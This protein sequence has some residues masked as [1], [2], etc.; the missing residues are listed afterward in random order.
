MKLF[1]S[2]L[3]LLSLL[4]CVGRPEPAPEPAAPTYL[5]QYAE[6]S[7]LYDEFKGF[8]A[9]ELFQRHGFTANSPYADWLQRVR[10]LEE[11]SG[12]AARAR[13]LAGL[14]VAWRQNGEMSEVTAG[15]VSRFEQALLT[16]PEEQDPAANATAPGAVGVAVSI[17]FSGD[18]QGVLTPQKAT[19]GEAGGIARRTSFINAVRT[20]HPDLFVLDA[21][22]ALATGFEGSDRN[23]RLLIHAMNAVGYDAMGLNSRDLAIGQARLQELAELASFPLVCS[24]LEFHGQAWPWIEPYVVL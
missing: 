12:L 3:C 19:K 4:S 1:L 17:V 18:T 15:F 8:R 24:N 11:Q 20:G 6:L 2:A 9:E 7:A 5:P 21:G 23:N 14:A 10:K 13:M 16:Q 22:D